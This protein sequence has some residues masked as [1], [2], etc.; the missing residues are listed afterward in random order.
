MKEKG[1]QWSEHVTTHAQD[2]HKPQ[3][4]SHLPQTAH[5]H[6][7]LWSHIRHE[8]NSALCTQTGLMT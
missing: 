2:S 7:S 6:S 1:S 3:T 8:T 4:V 5:V